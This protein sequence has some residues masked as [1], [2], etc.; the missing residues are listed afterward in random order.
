LLEQSIL[1]PFAHH[2]LS[3]RQKP[4]FVCA[5]CAPP[6]IRFLLPS[7]YLQAALAMAFIDTRYGNFN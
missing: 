4:A 1:L 6:P 7:P 2:S 5:V 3:N